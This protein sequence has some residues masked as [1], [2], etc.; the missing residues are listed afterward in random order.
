MSFSRFT[1][2]FAV[3]AALCAFMTVPASAQGRD[4]AYAVAGVYVDVNA[5]N[6]VAAR[7]AAFEAAERLGFERLVKRLTTPAQLAA[8][9]V[10]TPDQAALDRM[11]ISTDIEEEHLSATRYIGR[12]TVRFD[13]AQVRAILQAQNLRV[14]DTRTAP[15][16]IVPMAAPDALAVWRDVW[17]TGGFQE[18]LAPLAIAPDTL[19]GQPD[20]QAAAPV[21]QA[22]AAAS[23]LYATLRVQGSTASAQLVQVSAAGAQDRGTVSAN[24]SGSDAA[25][26][27]AA[28]AS[29]AQQASDVVQNDYKARTS[30]TPTGVQQTARVSASALYADEHQ[31]QTI[32]DA[33]GA[34]SATLISQIR[35]EA[36]NREGALVSFQFVGD[37]AQLVAELAR[38][39]VSLTDSSMGPVLRVAAQQ[40]APAQPH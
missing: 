39:G 25:S 19:Q 9:P 35:I 32:K 5:P 22:A 18:E 3:F 7:Q 16:L 33:L 28:L 24:I 2:V 26:L 40:P 14:I 30:S 8:A 17:T 37:R 38:R 12:L 21:A 11:T 29:L 20:W 31:W 6:A 36:V 4:N 34:A 23:A 10:T 1:A 15:T 13:P 27:R